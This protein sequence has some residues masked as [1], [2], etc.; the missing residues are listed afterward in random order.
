MQIGCPKEIK[1]REFRVGITP[2][3]AREAVGHGHAVLVETGAGAGSGFPDGDYAAV[4]AEIVGSA[5][6]VF[7]RAEMVVKV[8]EP[9]AE[10]RAIAFRTKITPG[11]TVLGDRDLLFQAISNLI[12]NAVK[13]TPRGG[14]VSLSVAAVD[15]TVLLTVSDSGPYR[16][17]LATGGWTVTRQNRTC[18][19]ADETTPWSSRTSTSWVPRTG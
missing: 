18:T 15:D 9:Q 5:E 13:F 2:A 10:E 14:A 3:A 7:A 19:V 1:T 12:D 8:K 4:G 16:L 17:R 6:E 11:L